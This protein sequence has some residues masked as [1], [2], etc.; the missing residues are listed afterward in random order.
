MITGI[1]SGLITGLITGFIVTKYFNKKQK[2]LEV[3]EFWLRYITKAFEKS[4]VH[5]PVDKLSYLEAIGN[6]ESEFGK[7][8]YNIDDL[9]YPMNGD[10]ELSD[11]ESEV[12]LNAIKVLNELNK[13][14]KEKGIK[15]Y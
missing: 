13:L 1:I 8:I 5:I 15:G 11:V 4:G 12:S 14:A 10:R 7:A 3:Y 6:M 2:N 9:L